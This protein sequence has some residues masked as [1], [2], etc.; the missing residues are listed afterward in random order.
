M[1]DCLA[2]RG[3]FPFRSSFESDCHGMGRFA[4][5][6]LGLCCLPADRPVDTEGKNQLAQR[7]AIGRSYRGDLLLVRRQ[8]S[9]FAR[10]INSDGCFTI[11]SHP[12]LGG[13]SGRSWRRR[14]PLRGSVPRHP[15]AAR[16]GRLTLS[17]W[18]AAVANELLL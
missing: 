8:R 14:E 5:D 16:A 13:A 4:D 15:G 2:H 1:D 6:R 18:R 10:S 11:A 7:W 12:C 17:S 3:N 9:I